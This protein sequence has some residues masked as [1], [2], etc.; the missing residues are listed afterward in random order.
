MRIFE[1]IKKGKK[2]VDRKKIK[3]L[4]MDIDGTLT[5][6]RIYIGADGE[7]M[8]AFNVKDGYAIAVILREH[9]IE[10][11]IITGRESE[12][13]VAR[14]KELKIKFIY[15]GISDKFAVLEKVTK[16]LNLEYENIAYMGDDL[17]DLVCM[18]KCGIS[19]CPADATKKVKLSSDFVSQYDGGKGAAREFIEWLVAPNTASNIQ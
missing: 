11:L 15:Q 4:A 6:G 9:G 14:C 3:V 12:I 16:E 8:K 13:V 17:P 18:G 5:D 2:M 1:K 19:G 10:P 7:I